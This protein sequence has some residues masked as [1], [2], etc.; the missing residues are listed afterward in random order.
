MTAITQIARFTWSTWDPPC[1]VGLRWA[2]WTLLSGVGAPHKGSA[3][4]EWCLVEILPSICSNKN[5]SAIQWVSVQESPILSV[6]YHTCT[7]YMNINFRKDNAIMNNRKTHS[8][9]ACTIDSKVSHIAH[10]TIEKAKLMIPSNL[11]Y[12]SHQISKLQCFSYH[13]AVVFSQSIEAKF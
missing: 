11:K 12:K 2:P 13:L 9:A 1:P 6:H 7:S 10:N 8:K 3:V 4:G 5:S